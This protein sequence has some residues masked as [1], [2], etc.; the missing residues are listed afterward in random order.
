MDTVGQTFEIRERFP[1]QDKTHRKIILGIV[2]VIIVMGFLITAISYHPNIELSSKTGASDSGPVA[3]V[4]ARNTGSFRDSSAVFTITTAPDTRCSVVLGSPQCTAIEGP[5]Q[6]VSCS[7]FTQRDSF[8]YTCPIGQDGVTTILTISSR[9][10][11]GYHKFYCTATS[12]TDV[13]PDIRGSF[14]VIYNY[15]FIYP[16]E[17]LG[18][19]K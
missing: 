19:I 10:Q 17:V 1:G 14:P 15:I 18:L 2:F 8:T 11:T 9:Y 5:P 4:S 3:M 7:T 6:R 12:C 16:F 13:T